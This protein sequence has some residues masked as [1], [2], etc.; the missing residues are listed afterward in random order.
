MPGIRLHN[1]EEVRFDLLEKFKKN[2]KFDYSQ[3]TFVT[4]EK[5]DSD[6]KETKFATVRITRNPMS[7]SDGEGREGK[8][9]EVLLEIVG[10]NEKSYAK[11]FEEAELLTYFI[12]KSSAQDIGSSLLRNPV[13]SS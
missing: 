6:S 12:F 7:E 5:L 11:A 9:D 3:I 13:T 2:G 1:Q 10:E 8:D 4:P